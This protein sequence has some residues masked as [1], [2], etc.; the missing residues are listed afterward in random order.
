MADRLNCIRPMDADKA[1]IAF[2]HQELLYFPTLTVAENM[3]ISHLAL[4]G[5]TPFLGR[6]T[7]CPGPRQGGNSTNSDRT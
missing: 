4:S 5:R 7:F 1:G 6:Q 2:I 3:F